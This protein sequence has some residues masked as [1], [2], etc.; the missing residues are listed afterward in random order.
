MALVTDYDCWHPSHDDV[1]IEQILGYLRANAEMA[2]KIL[3]S[4]IAAA[5]ARNA[6]L[7]VR[8][9]AAVRASSPTARAIPR[10]R[11]ERSRAADRKYLK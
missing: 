3:R 4:S 8:E 5:A 1:D 2:Q 9:R 6:R 7:R 10:E 11:K